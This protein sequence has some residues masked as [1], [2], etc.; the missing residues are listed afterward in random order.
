MNPKLV[1]ASKRNVDRRVSLQAPCIGQLAGETESGDILV[2]YAGAKAPMTARWVSRL[3][4][5]VLVEGIPSAVEVLLIFDG[6]DPGRPIITDFLAPLQVAPVRIVDAGGTTSTPYRAQVDGRR[7]TI[8]AQE[9]IV[10][11]CGKGSI[12][13]KRDGKIVLRGTQI[14]SRAS[15]ANK[16]KGASVSIN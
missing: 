9:R 2:Q 16:I 4:R 8:E 10:L 13:L 11:Q 7:V 5:D 12:T 1:H 15:G 14:L 3:S 6:G